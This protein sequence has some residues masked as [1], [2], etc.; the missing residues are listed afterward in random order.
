[1]GRRSS[2]DIVS[3][4][5]SWTLTA[6]HHYTHPAIHHYTRVTSPLHTH[7]NRDGLHQLKN[8]DVA[9][10][11]RHALGGMWIRIMYLL[12]GSAASSTKNGAA[13]PRGRG[14][15]EAESVRTGEEGG[16]G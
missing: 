14:A 10:S 7:N 8:A 12:P 6:I 2:S 4:N 1:M 3:R 9:E 16:G 5:I 13:G 15:E 11:P